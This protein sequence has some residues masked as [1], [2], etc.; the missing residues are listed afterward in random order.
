MSKERLDR[1]DL[2]T[3]TG[4]AAARLRGQF[5]ADVTRLRLDAGVS[6]RAL[7][8]GSNLDPSHLSSVE[9]GVSEPSLA[10]AAAIGTALGA[11][12]SFRLFPVSGPR[13]R[14]HLQSAMVECLLTETRGTWEPHVEVAVRRP[15]R[16]FVDVVLVQ[17]SV[18]VATEVHSELRRIEQIQRWSAEKAASLPSADGWSEWARHGLP[19]VDRLLVVRST[20]HN[21]EVVRTYRDLL[22]LSYPGDPRDARRALAGLAPWPGSAIVWAQVEGGRARLLDRL[23]P[24]VPP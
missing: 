19:R 8:R 5:G 15:A 1:R 12:V 7:A 14:D 21:R 22:A 20:R 11:D 18:I 13:I 9:H 6:L 3:A 4:R 10:T 23:P 24:G 16:G 17:P 2:R